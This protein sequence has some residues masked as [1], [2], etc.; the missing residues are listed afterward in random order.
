MVAMLYACDDEASSPLP[1]H[2][3]HLLL[4]NRHD[5]SR[6]GLCYNQSHF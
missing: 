4:L 5:T 1:F 6:K 3:L 2:S